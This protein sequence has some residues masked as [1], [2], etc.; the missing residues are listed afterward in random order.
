MTEAAVLTQSFECKRCVQTA[1][2]SECRRQC[3]Q[4]D[5]DLLLETA[6]RLRFIARALKDLNGGL[7]EVDAGTVAMMIE[8]EAS[9]IFKILE[10]LETRLGE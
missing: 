7:D 3:D 8:R 10:S 6:G 9:E 2:N 4:S 1:E 5:L